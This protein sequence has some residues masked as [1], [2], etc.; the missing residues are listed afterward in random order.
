MKN[1]LLNCLQIKARISHVTYR[2]L[3]YLCGI[4]MLGG[5]ETAPRLVNTQSGR[6]ETVIPQVDSGKAKNA[7]A[8]YMINSGWLPR[9]ADP[10]T[11]M[12]ERNAS[13]DLQFFSREIGA[14]PVKVQARFSILETSEGARII[15]S[16][17]QLSTFLGKAQEEEMRQRMGYMQQLLDNIRA[18][19]LGEPLPNLNPRPQVK[20]LT[21]PPGTWPRR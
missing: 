5:C 8:T 20:A 18:T 9:E 17:H 16:C 12:F 11:L 15:G 21:L 3:G 1:L 6:A 7:I 2:R 13:A 19:A 14:Q 4:L 10:L